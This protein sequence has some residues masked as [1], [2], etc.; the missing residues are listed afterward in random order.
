MSPRTLDDGHLSRLDAESGGAASTTLLAVLKRINARLNMLRSAQATAAERY[1]ADGADPLDVTGLAG[2]LAD[3]QT[4]IT[5]HATHDAGGDDALT[6]VPDHDHSGDAGDGGMLAGCIVDS[7]TATG[8]ADASTSVTT[9]GTRSDMVVTLTLPVASKVLVEFTGL[10]WTSASNVFGYFVIRDGDG[11]VLGNE[12]LQ[13][14]TDTGDRLLVHF[15]DLIELAAGTW[16][17]SLA[18]KTSTGTSY[19]GLRRITA[20][21]FAA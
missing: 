11:N 3:A 2:V 12:W 16:T 5:H 21:A 13:R 1:Q 17:L 19:L 8:S 20:M 6:T 7:A 18:W 4:P 9:Y 15:H 14:N 10:F